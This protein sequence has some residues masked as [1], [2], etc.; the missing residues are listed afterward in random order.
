MTAVGYPLEH[1]YY[2][3]LV[4]NGR[5]TGE[6]RPLAASGGLATPEMT[7]VVRGALL[8]PLLDV[9]LGAWGILRGHNG[10]YV[11][12]QSQ[13]NKANAVVLHLAVVPGDV[14][15]SLGGNMRVM[16]RLLESEM[17]VY[18][19]AGQR[20]R[21]LLLPAAGPPT[22]EAQID[23]MLALMTCT[24][25]R[26]DVV[27]QLLSAIV[28]GKS[29]VVYNAPTNPVQR[30]ALVEGLLALLPQPARPGVTFAMHALPTTRADAQIRFFPDGDAPDDA[31]CYDW[32]SGQVTHAPDTSEYSRFIISQFRLDPELVIEQMDALT[33]IAAWRIKRGDRLANAL[34][35]AAYRLTMDNSL[36]NNLPVP[37]DDAVRVLTEDPTLDDSL[38]SAYA[39]HVMAF[40][41]ALEDMGQ[42]EP[43]A[44]ML[45]QQAPLEASTLQQMTDALQNGK[46]EFVFRLVL[47]WLQNPLGP[48]GMEWISVVQAAAL[49]HLQS[50]VKANDAPGLRL[51]LLDIH[52]AQALAE[53]A[54]VVPRMLE[55]VLPVAAS[56]AALAETVFVLGVN[57]ATAE[58]LQR[59]LAAPGLMNQLPETFV[60]FHRYI[61]GDQ[62]GA[63]P[64]ELLVRAAIAFDEAWRT[65][66][67]IRLVELTLLA[68][69]NDLI[70][71]TALAAL[72]RAAGSQY[73]EAH[74]GT[75]R[76]LVR[77]LSTDELLPKLDSDSSRALLQILLARKAYAEL[78]QALTHHAR[79]LFTHETQGDYALMVRRLFLETPLTPLE[80]L[81]ALRN[82][83][84]GGLKP[85]PLAMAHV[86]ALKRANWPDN[87]QEVA[88]NL[89][90]LLL[91]NPL[92]A[93]TMPMASMFELL[94]FHVRRR[95]MKGT[96]QVAALLPIL[97][98]HRGDSGLSL[99]A[100]S[101]RL[102]DWD[103]QARLAA[104]EMLRQYIRTVDLVYAPRAVE[105][106]AA[107]LGTA[108]LP[109]LEAAYALRQ[110][111]DGEDMVGYAVL[112]HTTA[113][114][115][116][117][118]ALIYVEKRSGPSLKAL[119]G[120]LDSLVGGLSDDDRETLAV[121]ILDLGRAIEALGRQ[122][123]QNRPRDLNSHINALLDSSGQ[124]QT[125]LDVFR[126][127][128]GV[129]AR[130]RRIDIPMVQASS[131]HPF[132]DRAAPSLLLEIQMTLRVL[133]NLLDAFPPDEK[134]TVTPSALRAEIESLWADIAQAE[135]RNLLNEL[136][137]DF[138]AVPDLVWQIFDNG[139]TKALDENS[140][141]GRKLDANRQRPESTLELYRF[142]Y[143]Y[144]RQRSRPR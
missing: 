62:L 110:M 102:M 4:K 140:G 9:P 109:Q 138:Q 114:L 24:R 104:L 22:T 5:P 129:Y 71:P 1:F 74:D 144:F 58:Q 93:E 107:T 112:L 56:D 59:L 67:L 7:E 98:A 96:V 61:S 39:R 125:A 113:Q 80:T 92:V 23:A 16:M 57:Y 38:R 73:A 91:S 127:L 12:V 6:L 132:R 78:A 68:R 31:V 130:G 95:D 72:V 14:V 123:K 48:R 64:P 47:R 122:Q 36:L 42:A 2:G 111:M 128:G 63:A 51:F 119:F 49:V 11:F 136:G 83:D 29:I 108:I 8:P 32:A 75:F 143:G 70:D 141:L 65:L 142:V 46:A 20:L 90:A 120:D 55:T 69:R 66:V 28:D 3:Q 133:R 135:R 15:R 100:Q 115:L 101:H 79:V 88:T 40:A 53:M 13:V 43:I 10:K 27:E 82:L 87:L 124:P 76:W 26:L 105:R 41:V 106:L 89:T 84:A 86:G 60:E 139:D 77:T 52:Q 94:Q 25:E 118:T 33:P 121:A 85:W 99:I 117:D 18:E 126:L 137:T 35:Y 134:I 50:L 44:L 45:R 37:A 81:D 131:V 54:Y 116:A 30:A 34:N 21:P 17:P 19:S 97:A 103:N